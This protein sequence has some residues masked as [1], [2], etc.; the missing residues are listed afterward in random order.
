MKQPATAHTI[1]ATLALRHDNEAFFYIA[2]HRNAA[3]QKVLSR[4]RAEC[5]ID[6]VDIGERLNVQ[7]YLSKKP[8]TVGP[9]VLGWRDPSRKRTSHRLRKRF[10]TDTKSCSSLAVEQPVLWRQQP[11]E[12]SAVAH[13][14]IEGM[15]LS[16]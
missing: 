9:F 11:I 16:F 10:E 6:Q 15:C 12:V 3:S 7:P 13:P 5:G 2:I 1:Q 8:G 4:E 14:L